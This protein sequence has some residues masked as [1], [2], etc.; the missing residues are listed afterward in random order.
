MRPPEHG[1]VS[2]SASEVLLHL[3]AM[4]FRRINGFE[5]RRSIPLSLEGLSHTDVQTDQLTEVGERR[6]LVCEEPARA[7]MESDTN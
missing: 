5:A 6:A 4:F 7:A 3:A 2:V 1:V